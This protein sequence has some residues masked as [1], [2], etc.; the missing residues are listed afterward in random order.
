[1]GQTIRSRAKDATCNLTDTNKCRAA[2]RAPP[3][4]ASTSFLPVLDG[5]AVLSQI[6]RDCLHTKL[7]L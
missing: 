3:E 6:Y 1:M 7:A 2:P 5:S 4:A